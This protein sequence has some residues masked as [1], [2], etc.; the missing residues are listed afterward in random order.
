MITDEKVDQALALIQKGAGNYEYFFS[1]LESPSWIEPLSRRGRFGH[2]PAPEY[3]GNLVRFPRWPE[4]EYLLRMATIAPE[5]VAAALDPSCFQSDNPLVHQLFLDIGSSL[6]TRHARNIAEQEAKWV[7]NQFAL[8]T[9]YP[10]KAAALIVHL[11]N[12]GEPR[13]AMQLT[14]AILA[15]CEPQEPVESL[16]SQ[17]QDI[18]SPPWRPSP[19]PRGK[20]DPV[21]MELFLRKVTE[22]LLEAAPNEFLRMLA[23]NV[24]RAVT[25]HCSNHPED[26]NDYSTI[27]RQHLSHSSHY[28]VLD[29]YLTGLTRAISFLGKQET[30]YSDQIVSALAPYRWPIFDRLRA[31]VYLEAQRA[32][33]ESVGRF[34]TDPKRFV[35]ASDNPEF[36]ELLRKWSR[37]LSKNRVDQILQIIDGGPDPASYQYYLEHRVPLESVDS[38]RKRIVEQWRLAWL[39]PLEAALDEARL[40]ELNGLISEYNV[41]QPVIRTS[42]AFAIQSQ[43]PTDLDTLKAFSTEQVIE[44]LRTWK[45]QSGFP[46]DQPSRGGLGNSLSQW[47][48]DSPNDVSRI[49]AGFLRKDLHPTY[50]T[51]LLDAF[52]SALKSEKQFDVYAVARAVEW[53]SENTKPEEKQEHEGW[54]E[55]TWNW[56]HMSGAR[57]MSELFLHE[58]RLDLAKASDLFR[59]VRALC[60]VPSPTEQDE[61]EYKKKPNRYGS[62]ALN[63]PRPVGVEA[64]IRYGRWL[65]IATPE[66]DFRPD[67]LRSVFDLLEQKLDP[68]QEPS[69]GV[70]E[71]FGMQ[72]R[73]LAWLDLNWFV[74]VLPRLFPSKTHRV[75]DRFSWNSYLQFGSPL[76]GTFP[77]MRGRYEMALNALQKGDKEVADTERVLGSHVMQYYAHGAIELDD[78]LM[79]QFFARPSVA[80]RA[81]VIGDIG[82]SL[83]HETAELSPGVQTRLMNLWES[84]MAALSESPRADADE[85]GTFGWWLASRKFPEEWAVRQ[86]VD[87]IERLRSLRPDFAAVETMAQLA[88][89]FPY[90]AVRIVHVVFEEDRDGWAIHGWSQHLRGILVEALKA[91]PK[92]RAEAEETIELL[93]SRGHRQ[94]RDL[95]RL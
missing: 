39:Y 90:E 75:L 57:Y 66:E 8:L 38:E 34:L 50:I 72:F 82:W 11:V 65:K 79:Q 9:L 76:L 13:V 35:R 69:V 2:P 56:A 33:D 26:P 47:V 94:Y 29:E 67:Q 83:G 70:R 22:P 92:A 85:L 25:I 5:Q 54:I 23:A 51:S 30:D 4:G 91:G 63:S 68:I 6:P 24:D 27:W 93:V 58:E 45:P 64:L 7:K 53:V 28:G 59:A 10:E 44:Y 19:V 49:L 16:V 46:F 37:S 62:M 80:L 18:Q 60:F 17:K 89:R 73:T 77:A 43:S 42:G 21:W 55:A 3:I 86:A 36:L 61:A 20:I 1:K 84:R 12:G 74:S 14:S 41:P 81:Q 15:V 31:F 95:P 52:T 40:R 32:S 87:V 88:P 48:A 71:M 78:P